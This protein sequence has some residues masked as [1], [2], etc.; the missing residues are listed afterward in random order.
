MTSKKCIQDLLILSDKVRSF[1][2]YERNKEVLKEF[3]FNKRDLI[4]R[5]FERN[6]VIFF[7]IA[8]RKDKRIYAK[9][10]VEKE[11]IDELSTQVKLVRLAMSQNKLS[12]FVIIHNNELLFLSYE[13]NDLCEITS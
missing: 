12:C 10:T 2:C 11:L 4:E 9:I 6:R 3:V 7:Y 1:K 13:I 8:R 5:N